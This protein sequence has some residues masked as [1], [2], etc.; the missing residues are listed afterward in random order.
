M[1]QVLSQWERSKE[2]AGE[3]QDQRRV[4]SEREKDGA[5]EPVNIVSSSSLRPGSG[6]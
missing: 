3:E 5:G 6:M 1:F 4:A 2:R